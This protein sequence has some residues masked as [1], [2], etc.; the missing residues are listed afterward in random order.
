MVSIVPKKTAITQGI[1][2]LKLI[3]EKTKVLQGKNYD[4]HQMTIFDL[5][6]K[7]INVNFSKVDSKWL[8]RERHHI[9]PHG[10]GEKLLNFSFIGRLITHSRFGCKACGKK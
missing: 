8:C 5:V 9:F 10:L 1:G 3:K 6:E 7:S 4:S 2:L